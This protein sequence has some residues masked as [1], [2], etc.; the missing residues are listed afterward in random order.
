MPVKLP[1]PNK[2]QTHIL[3]FMALDKEAQADPSKIH[4]IPC[5]AI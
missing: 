3:V 2:T 1:E 5:F 4:V